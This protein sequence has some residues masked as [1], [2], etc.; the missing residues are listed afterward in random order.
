MTQYSDVAAD[1]VKEHCVNTFVGLLEKFG[2]DE[3]L[4]RA[5]L[6]AMFKLVEE[7][8]DAMDAFKE[9][10][11]EAVLL[12]LVEKNKLT[13]QTRKDAAAFLNFVVNGSDVGGT[14]THAQNLAMQLLG[15]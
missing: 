10:G 6:E 2:E 1:E 15:D 4:V 5:V 13:D 14:V 12:K 3:D 9:A 11:L 7:N 8:A